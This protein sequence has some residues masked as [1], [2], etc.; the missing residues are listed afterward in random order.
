VEND[1]RRE[2]GTCDAETLREGLHKTCTEERN[3]LFT[4]DSAKSVG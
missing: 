2:D 1:S 4:V 3:L